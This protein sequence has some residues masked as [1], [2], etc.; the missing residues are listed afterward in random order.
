MAAIA[1]TERVISNKINYLSKKGYKISLITYE[2][3]NHPLA[4]ELDK[5]VRIYDI[6]TRFFTLGKYNIISKYFRFLK[7]KII[8]KNKLDSIIQEIKPDIIICT[9]YSIKLAN[10]ILYIANKYD[11]KTIIESHVALF[12]IMRHYDFRKSNIQYYFAYIQ[13]YRAIHYIKKFNALVVLTNGDAKAWSKYKKA[14]VIPNII[15]DNIHIKDEKID[16]YYRIISVGRLEVQ[17]GYDLLIKA[18]S[19]IYNKHKPWKID[20]F[21]DGSEKDRLINSIKELNMEKTITINPPQKNI[22]NEYIKSD[23]FVM[24]SRYEG[25]GLVLA[26]AMSCGI[27][28][29]AFDCPYGPNEIISDGIDG[30]IV[31]NENIGD[32]ASKIE[33]MILHDKERLKMGINAVESMKRYNKDTIMLSWIELF[34]EMLR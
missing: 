30:F 31:K 14:I 20:I 11:S 16:P 17:K 13:D 23:F 33:W 18:F 5:S 6:G 15:N 2:Q 34:S 9:T 24:S 29:I 21:G 4:F 19:I 10:E 3:G 28:V 26:E 12:S 22:Y 32:L 8:F 25:F 7:L 27:P 1:G